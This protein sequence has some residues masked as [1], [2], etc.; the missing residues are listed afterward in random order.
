MARWLNQD[1][2]KEE[3]PIKGILSPERANKQINKNKSGDPVDWDKLELEAVD[4]AAH[5]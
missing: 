2:R 5:L 4:W 1:A 3:S